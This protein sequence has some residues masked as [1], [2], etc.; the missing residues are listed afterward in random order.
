MGDISDMPNTISIVSL[1]SAG[2]S[3][4]ALCGALYL[5]WRWRD[6]RLAFLTGLA[7][8]I[9][10]RQST[11]LFSG[12]IDGSFPFANGLPDLR[13]LVLSVIV[14]LAVFF[15]DRILVERRESE[16]ALRYSD[17]RFR[18]LIDGSI[19]GI[20]ILSK[21]WKMLFANNATARIFGYPDVEEMLALGDAGSLLAPFERE[22]IKAMAASRLDGQAPPSQYEM[23]GL[24]KD[25]TRIWLH[26]HSRRV[27]WEGSAAIQSTVVDISALKQREAELHGAKELAEVASR[28]KTEFLA[29]MSHELR[30]PLTAIIGFAEVLEGEMFGPHTNPAYKEYAADIRDSGMHLLEIINDILDVS[31]IEAGKVELHEE[32]VEVDRLVEAALTLVRERADEGGLTLVNKVVAGPL[33]VVD[34]RLLKQ[35]LVNLLSNAVKFTPLGGTVTVE[36][37][38][39]ADDN[40]F[41]LRVSDTGIGIAPEDIETVMLPFRQADGTLSRTHEGTGLGLPLARS[42]AQL[43]DGDIVLSSEPGVGT[44]ASLLLPAKRVVELQAAE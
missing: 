32:A 24:R 13:N 14:F 35:I 15:I 39:L 1:I 28:T 10:V 26:I 43:H 20:L 12:S 27:E 33:L 21:D 23:H 8:L 34:P 38:R 19:Q 6:W 11:L 41:A 37:G 36:S 3:L 18:N 29:N 42:L 40:G 2:V 5:P 16:D 30:T 22:R 7:T 44:T 9:V 4:V 17:K 25:G 31:K